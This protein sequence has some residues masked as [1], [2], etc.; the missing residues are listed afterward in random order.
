MDSLE[1][2]DHGHKERRKTCPISYLQPKKKALKTNN[3]LGTNTYEGKLGTLGRVASVYQT[4]SKEVI[5]Y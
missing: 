3:D 5:L 1:K 2:H 4:L